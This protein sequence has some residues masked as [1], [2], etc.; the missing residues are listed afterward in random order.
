MWGIFERSVKWRV[1][2]ITTKRALISMA[3][4]SAV[5]M[6]SPVH[7]K[8]KNNSVFGSAA[9]TKMSHKDSEKVSGKG[10]SAAY[11]GYYG[12]YYATLAINYGS[13]ANRY[14]WTT[15]SNTGSTAARTY[16]YRA[17]YYA[18][19]ARSRYYNAYRYWNT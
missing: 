16:Y 9:I 14:N 4:A 17:Y 18:G 15:Y 7:A 8:N 6:I 12:N 3:V 19:L 10:N 13:L 5:V 1:V 2:M 11:Y